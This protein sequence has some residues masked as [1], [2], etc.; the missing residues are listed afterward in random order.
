MRRTIVAALFVSVTSLH[1]QW[2]AQAPANAPRTADGEIDLDAGTPRASDGKPDLS[3]TWRGG[4]RG[5]T[6]FSYPGRNVAYTAGVYIAPLFV[7]RRTAYGEELYNARQATHSKD[8]PRGLCLPMGIVQLHTSAGLA[9][10]IQTSGELVILY[11]MNGERRQIFLD[12]RPL[13]TNDPQPF[14]NG[15]SVGRWEGDALVVETTH[16][17]DG[18][19]LDMAGNPLTDAGRVTERFRRPSYGRMEID[20]TI[21]DTKAYEAP[22]TV[23]W[24]QRIAEDTN[25]I[26]SVC[27]ENNRFARTRR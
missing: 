23:R 6:G 14:W 12:G 26:E 11:E 2:P 9:K 10:Y 25:L 18:G 22:F 5:P 17:R 15:Y 7:F 8:N 3:G 16:F 4:G 19:W 13:P 1:A 24:N 27:L 21:A 20:I